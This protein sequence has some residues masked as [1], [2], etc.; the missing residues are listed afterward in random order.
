MRSAMKFI[1]RL[2]S[3]VL[4]CTAA[5]CVLAQDIDERCRALAETATVKVV[6]EDMPIT[7]DTRH[8]PEELERMHGKG[9]RPNHLVLGMTTAKPT[10]RMKVEHRS[11]VGTTGRTCVAGSVL[12]TLGFSDLRVY[13]AS[14][15][16]NPCQ[17]KIV[18]EHEL[19]HVRI[20]RSHLRIG[21]RL[22][23][24]LLQKQLSAPLYL[25]SRDEAEPALRQQLNDTVTPLVQ[26]LTAVVDIAQRE[27]DTPESYRAVESRYRACP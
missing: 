15:L 10:A 24:P 13:L 7:W 17:R 2:L 22:L 6:F 14:T 12:L 23:E 18:E 1:V 3:V 26:Q 9:A 5:R 11:V 20:W 19:E 16:T 8:R 27:I 25:D 4:A 21:A